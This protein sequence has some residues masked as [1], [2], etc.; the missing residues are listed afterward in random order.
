M[1]SPPP[2]VE[3]TEERDLYGQ[4]HPKETAEILSRKLKQL[5]EEVEKIPPADKARLVEAQSKCPELLTDRFKLMFLRCEVFNADLAA[6]RYAF[7]WEQRVHLFGPDKAF[8]PLTLDKAL[9]DDEIALTKGFFNYTGKVDPTG[10]SIMFGDPSNLDAKAYEAESMCR[11][12]WYVVHTLLENEETQK[13]GIVIMI[14][15]HHVKLSQFDKKLMKMNSVSMRK[16][17][18]VRISAVHVCQPP[19]IFSIIF[20]IVKLFMGDIVRKRFRVHFGT[21]EAVLRGLE[22]TGLTKDMIAS[23][24]GGNVNIDMVQ[25]I[26]ERRA[27]GK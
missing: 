5:E 1:S 2:D 19:K 12:L 25:W 26:A 27:A 9:K 3:F 11:T 13:K 21:Q 6:K 14:W 17:L 7:Y 18:P 15:P 8:L 10:R 22:E 4:R 23:Q 24:L 16:C 20:P